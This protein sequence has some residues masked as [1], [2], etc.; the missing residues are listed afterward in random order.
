MTITVFTVLPL[1]FMILLAFTNYNQTNGPPNTL[2]TWVGPLKLLANYSLP[3]AEVASRKPSL[4][5]SNGPL[6]GLS[7]RPLLTT[8]L[9]SSLAMMINRKGD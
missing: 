6:S 4:I 9:V 3:L 8:Y 1:I 5:F 2:F 7:L